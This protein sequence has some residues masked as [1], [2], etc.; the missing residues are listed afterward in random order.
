MTTRFSRP[1]VEEKPLRRW[2][3]TYW[4]NNQIN[5]PVL[6]IDSRMKPTRQALKSL[7]QNCTYTITGGTL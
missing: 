6:A 2:V 3:I 4:R 1:P 5:G 7:P